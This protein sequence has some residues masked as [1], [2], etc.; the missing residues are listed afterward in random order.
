MYYEKELT[1]REI[2]RDTPLTLH[3]FLWNEIADNLDK[4]TVDAP[5]FIMLQTNW[6]EW[7]ARDMATVI[8]HFL[9]EDTMS[10]LDKELIR[11]R[12]CVNDN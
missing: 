2:T 9:F 4:F 1:K 7:L 12:P 8:A 6:G 11:R 3:S 10:Y 5:K